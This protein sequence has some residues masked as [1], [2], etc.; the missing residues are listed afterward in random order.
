MVD[1]FRGIYQGSEELFEPRT[2]RKLPMNH[3]YCFQNPEVASENILREVREAL[4]YDI[5]ETEL[6]NHNVR[7]V[8][9]SKVHRVLAWL[10]AGYVLL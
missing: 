5:E 2:Q 4:G 10:T 7:N 9:P 8:A 6:I 3:V 1:A